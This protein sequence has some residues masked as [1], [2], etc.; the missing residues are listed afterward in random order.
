MS[1]HRAAESVA[2]EAM[3]ISDPKQ[4]PL[5]LPERTTQGVGTGC[6]DVVGAMDCTGPWLIYPSK[7]S[8]VRFR[9]E[10]Y[11]P[12]CFT[13]PAEGEAQSLH[14]ATQLY[15]P[16]S[17]PSVIDEQVSAMAA[18]FD[19]SGWQYLDDLRRH[20]SH[21]PLSTY[22]SWL[23]LAGN[24]DTLASAVLRMEVDESFCGRIRDELAVIWECIPLEIWVRAF[25]RFRAWLTQ[26]GLP[27]VLVEN[28]LA[29]RKS[30]LKVVVP[31]FEHLGD[32]LSTG[33]RPPQKPPLEF[34]LPGCYQDLRRHHEANDR[35][36]TDLGKELGDWVDRQS[37]PLKVRR[38]SNIE[39]S[40]AVTYLPIFMA[41]VTAGK[42]TTATLPGPPDLVKFVIRKTSD[43]DRHGWY[44]YVHALVV[45]HLLSA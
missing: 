43:F 28:L 16:A 24:G 19:H 22:Q 39:Y 32:Y 23:A 27:D 38:L 42:V 7:S 40:D 26:K 21:L 5:G 41:H 11:V 1:G 36:P 4:A 14:R 17:N 37:L 45:W 2:V 34:I 20:F 12:K 30:V 35:W 3:L 8:T 44:L 6:F 18:E 33:D 9:P 10:L 31:G 15:H 25:S 29:N 13:V